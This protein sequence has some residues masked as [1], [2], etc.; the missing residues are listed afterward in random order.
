M[1]VKLLSV[2]VAIC[3][4]ELF[5]LGVQAP[6]DPLFLF[7]SNSPVV[8]AIR[9]ILVATA[10]II[11]FKKSFVYY[12]SRSAVGAVGLFLV[13]IGTM[14]AI[15]QTISDEFGVYLKVLDFILLMVTGLV[16]CLATL[17]YPARRRQLVWR[18]LLLRRMPKPLALKLSP[19]INNTGIAKKV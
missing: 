10:L 5:V 7:I 3:V 14:G 19:Y 15:S 4:G 12:F 8:V 17:S 18:R 1:V 6:G 13:F 16:F 2:V 9:L 11:S